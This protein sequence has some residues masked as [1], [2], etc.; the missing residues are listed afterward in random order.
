M[1]RGGRF[2][3]ATAVSADGTV[4]VGEARTSEG[5][6][7]AFRWTSSI[8]MSELTVASEFSGSAATAVSADGSAVLVHTYD[9]QSI[10]TIRATS[11]PRETE[12]GTL[13]RLE[14]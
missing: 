6:L 12:C 7:R 5:R 10:P 13:G 4:I 14:G 8:G 2:S 9:D 3:K 11:G 1:E